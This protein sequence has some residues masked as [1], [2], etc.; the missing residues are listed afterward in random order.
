MYELGGKDRTF[1][2]S[3]RTHGYVFVYVQ[4]D[5]TN[6]CL[7]VRCDLL[8]DFARTLELL[9]DGSVHPPLIATPDELR[10]TQPGIIGDF[11]ARDTNLHPAPHTSR[12]HLEHD[13]GTSSFLPL[14][15][16]E[17][18]RLVP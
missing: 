14:P 1:N 4:I 10:A 15:C 9:L 7:R 5:C 3:D 18:G 2:R 12:P 6:L 13:G 16:I 17:G 8:L 11:S